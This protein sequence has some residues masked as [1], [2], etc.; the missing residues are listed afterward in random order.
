MS[1]TKCTFCGSEKILTE[2]PYVELK[3]IGEAGK[4]IYAPKMQ[5]CCRAQEQNHKYRNKFVGQ[6][7][8]IEDIER[9]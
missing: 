8:S 7:P 2:T 1:D 6:K 4:P 3:E 5:F 9:G